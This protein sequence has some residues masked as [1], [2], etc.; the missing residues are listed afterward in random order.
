MYLVQL[1]LP[2]YDASGT[3]F[4][5]ARFDAVRRA[6]ADQFGGVT[7]YMRAPAQGLWEDD[8]GHMERDEVLLFEVMV[9]ALDHGWWAAYRQSLEADFAQDEILVRASPVERL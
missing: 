9:E 2:V 1:L 4:P 7:A 8:A 6:L 5:R 3:P